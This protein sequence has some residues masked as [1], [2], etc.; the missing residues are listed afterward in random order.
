MRVNGAEAL[1]GRW[2][3]PLESIAGLARVVLNADF[4][5]GRVQVGLGSFLGNRLHPIFT[6]LAHANVSAV[7]VQRARLACRHI[8]WLCLLWGALPGGRLMTTSLKCLARGRRIDVLLRDRSILRV[9]VLGWQVAVQ[10]LETLLRAH[11]LAERI[12]GSEEA[13]NGQV[14]I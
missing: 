13:R 2:V 6:H 12:V 4:R 1:K 8:L 5:V 11:V 9:V 7:G 14:H 3:D 10:A